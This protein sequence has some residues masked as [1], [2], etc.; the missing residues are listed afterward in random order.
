MFVGYYAYKSFLCRKL[1][2]EQLYGL[3]MKDLNNLE[4]QLEFSLQ[5][6]RIKKVRCLFVFFLNINI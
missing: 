2:G 4:N 1:M 3:S 5:S 6:I